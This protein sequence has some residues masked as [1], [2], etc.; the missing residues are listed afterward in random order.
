VGQFDF[1]RRFNSAGNIFEVEADF[2]TWVDYSG[3]LWSIASP[4]VV[5]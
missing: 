5:P 4:I 3:G 2:D 1:N